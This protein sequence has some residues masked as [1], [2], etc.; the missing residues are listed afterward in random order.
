MGV[1]P[2]QEGG[3]PPDPSRCF[4]S[5]FRGKRVVVCLEQQ[6]LRLWGQVKKTTAG[7]NKAGLPFCP[8]GSVPSWNSPWGRGKSA[9]P[10]E[11]AASIAG[12]GVLWWCLR[13][14]LEQPG[15]FKPVPSGVLLYWNNTSPCPPSPAGLLSWEQIFLLLHSKHKTWLQTTP[16]L[17]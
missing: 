15:V 5:S 8:R 17:E 1:I 2:N 14:P 16:R 11:A 13:P 7:F 3:E 4:L 6:Q 12:A 9:S 10:W